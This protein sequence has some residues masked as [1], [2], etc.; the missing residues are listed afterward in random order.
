MLIRFWIDFEWSDFEN[1]RNFLD[2]KK[3]MGVTA[4]NLDDAI[5]IV[6]KTRFK[7][8][9]PKISNVIE[10]IDISTIEDKG[11]RCNMELPL[12]R[13]VWYPKGLGFI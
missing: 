2:V 7:D 6:K 13:G 8:N 4:Y 12:R 9:L 11:V 3:G 5:E 1:P 10:N